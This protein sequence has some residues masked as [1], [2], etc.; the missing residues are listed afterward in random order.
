MGIFDIKTGSNVEKVTVEG[1]DVYIRRLSALERDTF[2]TQ[3]LEYKP[4]NS[5]I[6]IRP[7]YVAWC[8]CD[9][10]GKPE[11]D[12]GLDAKVSKEFLEAVAKVSSL[13]AKVVQPVFAKASEVNALS[14][15]D[16]GELEKN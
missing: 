3:W 4:A 7:F 8:L 16:V 1:Q 13:P 9:S 12:P 15:G 6:G 14:S 10:D 5:M 2:E 11:F